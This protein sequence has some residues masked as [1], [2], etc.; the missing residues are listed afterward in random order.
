[1]AKV[2]PVSAAVGVIGSVIGAKE[3]KKARAKQDALAQRYIQLFDTL[4]GKTAE[5]ERRGFFDPASRL[6]LLNR[7]TAFYEGRDL[8]NLAGALRIAGYRPGDSEI[9]TRLDAVKAKYRLAREKMA[10]EIRRQSFADLLSAYASANPQALNA[11]LALYSS[12]MQDP[13]AFFQAL[14]PYLMKKEK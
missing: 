10:D 5:A 8:G 7:E 2:D 12:R 4:F 3:N 14:M 1:M 11:P 13:T 6:A 9:G